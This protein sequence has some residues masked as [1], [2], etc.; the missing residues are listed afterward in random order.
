MNI[1]EGSLEE[2]SYYLGSSPQIFG[3]RDSSE[4]AV[5]LEEISRLLHGYAKGIRTGS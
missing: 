5:S 3:Y 1:A 2:T 4:L